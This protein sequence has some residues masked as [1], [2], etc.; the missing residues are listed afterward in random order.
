MAIPAIIEMTKIMIL[1]FPLTEATKPG[2]GQIPVQ[3]HP[4]PNKAAP[5]S[6]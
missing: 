4:T 5:V 2:P 6:N 3:P 1:I